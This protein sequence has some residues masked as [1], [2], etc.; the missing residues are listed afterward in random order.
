MVRQVAGIAAV[1]LLSAT[2][3]HAQGAVYT[4]TKASADVHLSPS[5][6]SPVLGKTPRGTTFEV[7]RELGS[8]VRVPWSEAPDSEGYLHVTWGTIS[9]S[10]P[11]ETGRMIRTSAASALPEP[12]SVPTTTT[13]VAIDP[14]PAPRA[15]ARPPAPVLP[16]HIVGLG[17]RLGGQT[18]GFAATG[19]AWSSGPFGVQVELGRTTYTSTVSADRL[20][21]TQIAPSVIYSLPDVVTNAV[22][23]RPYVGSGASIYRSTLSG[24]TP[25]V[26][27]P[28]DTGLGYQAFGGAEFTWANL[29]QLAVSADLRQAWVPTSVDGFELGG[30]GF[31][32]SAHW[33]VK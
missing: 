2:S 20:S 6:G 14:Q 23:V 11:A 21:S 28:V 17:G 15:L 26:S 16:S 8:W 5:T 31:S 9:R 32:M 12:E 30:L 18:A 4:V 3:L 27:G 10:E 33:Y 1:L 13:T 25:G 7:M 22:W 19:R 24:P 29:P